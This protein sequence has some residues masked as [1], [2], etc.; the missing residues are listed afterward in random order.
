MDKSID[1]NDW[2]TAKEAAEKLGTTTKYVRVLAIQYN[3]FKTYKFHEHMML[4]WKADVD[5][6][7]RVEKG[8]TGRRLKKEQ[9]TSNNPSEMAI[10]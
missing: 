10:A 6:Y 5:A 8:N 7:G 3:K 1:L 4:Y 2:Y 9:E